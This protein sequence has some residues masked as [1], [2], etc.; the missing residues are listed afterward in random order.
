MSRGPGA[1]GWGSRSIGRA[2]P[3]PGGWDRLPVQKADRSGDRPVVPTRTKPS[4]EL[5]ERSADP[6]HEREDA[7]WF[8]NPRPL[9]PGLAPEQTPSFERFS[10]PGIKIPLFQE[11]P[12][13]EPRPPAFLPSVWAWPGSPGSP[14]R[15]SYSCGRPSGRWPSRPRRRFRLRR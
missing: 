5:R 7:L 2:I 3:V 10:A 15:R 9:R 13:C 8:L 6:A 12:G 14:D 4:T 1:R 11:V